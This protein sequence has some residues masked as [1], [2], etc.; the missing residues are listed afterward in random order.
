[1]SGAKEKAKKKLVH[2]FDYM[3]GF[4]L[5]NSDSN[6]K[7]DIETAVDLI[8]VAAVEELQQQTNHK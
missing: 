1:M 5:A 6:I 2:C 4:T 3:S 8:I 7:A